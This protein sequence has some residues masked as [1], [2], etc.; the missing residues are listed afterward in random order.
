MTPQPAVTPRSPIPYVVA[1]ALLFGI[2]TLA[3]HIEITYYVLMTS[4]FY[5]AWR[6][7]GAWRHHGMCGVPLRQRSRRWLGSAAWLLSMV[8]LGMTLGAVQLVPLYELVKESFRQGSASLQQV[9]DWA[10]PNRQIVTF[11]LPDAFG[12]PTHHSYFNIWTRSWIP[13]T[14]NALGEPL[15]KITGGAIDWGA[16]NYVEGQTTWGCSPS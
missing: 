7:A 11:L 2:Q 12:N 3:G 5:A 10:W 8:V 16:K 13:V 1:G 4:A 6:L 15:S 9:L 14:T